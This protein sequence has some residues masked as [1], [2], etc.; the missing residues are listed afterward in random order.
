MQIRNVDDLEKAMQ[1]YQRLS[2]AAV[3]SPEGRRRAEIDAQIKAFNAQHRQDL[4]KG[5]PPSG[6]G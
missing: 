6:K 1:E 4:T 2:E 5:R 3:D